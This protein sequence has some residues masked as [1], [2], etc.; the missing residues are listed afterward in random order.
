MSIKNLFI[1]I[2]SSFVVLLVLLR[3][4]SVLML[5]NQASL[6]ENQQIRYL[7]YQTADELRQSSM[8]LT[9]LARTYVS[10]GDS[11]YE[12]LYWE[13]LDI[14]NGKKARPDGRT[15][16]L[17]QIMIDLGFT[18]AEFAKITEAGKNSDGL[19]WTETI[20]MNAVKGK[21]HDSNKNF[22]I[23]KNP[24]L[25]LA[26]ELMFNDQYH[27]FV[28]K[29]MAPINDFFK[30]L[31]ER[32]KSKVEALEAKS[33]S[34][35]WYALIIIALLIMISIFSYILITRKISAP[36]N[37][38][39]REVKL[40]GEG[41][42]T[43]QIRSDA[44]DEIG[45]LG[46]SLNTMCQN[47]RKMFQDIDNRVQTLIS[48]SGK[49]S[50]ASAQI[51]AN[52]ET[53][54]K[55]SNTVAAA[56][57]EMSTNMNSVA[58]ATE[59]A[60]AN[61]QT[62][63]T[64]VEQ[65]SSTIQELAGNTEKGSKTSAV[66]VETAREVSEK[67]N[68]LGSA[69]SQIS[70]VTETIKDISEQTNLLALNATI[71]AAR[72]GEAGKGFAVVAGEIKALALQTAEAT[73]EINEKISGVQTSTEESVK[74]IETIVKVINDIDEI[75]T[76]LATAVEEQSA[77]TSEISDNV[78]Q[79]GLGVQEINESVNQISA[80]TGEVTQDVAQISRAAQET[81]TGSKQINENAVDLSNLAE[82]LNEMVKRFKI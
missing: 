27:K 5:K 18:D 36:V 28:V 63:V 13:I 6:N 31:D 42:L 73:T 66:A 61:I 56:S 55:K 54:A 68:E 53:T 82:E 35:L 12:D 57:E 75:V 33:N 29:I 62:I 76:T 59:Q 14:R 69:A 17:S 11:Q 23:K 20:A 34:Y 47:L 78:S 67:I 32:T 58:A 80:V 3:F 38:L 37:T 26:R 79:A 4:V 64:A 70:K 50:D 43:R 71:E 52:S 10:T 8:D 30:M 39:V 81:N 41:D 45:M 25:K 77:T 24:D 22:T 40:I 44:N 9:R 51:T 19:V 16:P 65:M 7:S 15:I 2:F 72:A 1:T 60:T 48:S 49:F 21:F 74:T 46:Q